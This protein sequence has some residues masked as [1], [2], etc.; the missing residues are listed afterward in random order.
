[1]IQFS[2]S[3]LALFFVV[4]AV[5][6]PVER[7]DT[8]DEVHLAITPACGIN[9]LVA[10][11]DSYTSGGHSNGR[12]L[13]PAVLNG[14]N[15]LAGGRGT[16]GPVW[17]EDLASDS[18]A[19][20]KDYAAFGAVVNTT[21][22]PSLAGASD[23]LQQGTPLNQDRQITPLIPPQPLYT[24]FFGINDVL[25]SSTDENH[26]PQAAADLLAQI[27]Q[28]ATAPTNAKNIVVLDDCR[29]GAHSPHR[30]RLEAGNFAPLWDAV[31]GMTPGFA[32]FGYKT[33]DACIPT[34]D[35]KDLSGECS[36]PLNLFYWLPGFLAR[37]S[38]LFYVLSIILGTDIPRK[39]IA[40]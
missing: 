32:A 19:T 13:P 11:G 3:L 5:H 30:R 25:A 12:P 8:S 36:S 2:T 4:T 17:A 34:L 37:P 18:G 28:L 40:L 10:F 24:V 21:L 9:T 16:G 22:W 39:G 6:F 26:L 31:L 7:Y 14:I 27:K 38:D 1:M 20:I 23:F 29:R 35:Q 15:P 33:P